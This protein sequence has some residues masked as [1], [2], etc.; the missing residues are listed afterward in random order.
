M[1]VSK[2]AVFKVGVERKPQLTQAHSRVWPCVDQ[3][4]SVQTTDSALL[5]FLLTLLTRRSA[6][7]SLLFRPKVQKGSPNISLFPPLLNS[8]SGEAQAC[9]Y[10]SAAPSPEQRLSIAWAFFPSLQSRG[11]TQHCF[12][13]PHANH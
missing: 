12:C 1:H 8:P 5:Y 13:F 11:E 7:L 2:S 3:V 10:F 6:L 9:F 4:F